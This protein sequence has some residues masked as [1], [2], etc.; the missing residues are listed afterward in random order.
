MTGSAPRRTPPGPRARLPYIPALDSLRAVAVVAVLAYHHDPAAV[1]GGWLGVSLFFTLSGFLIGGLLLAEH[2]REGRVDLAGFWNRRIRRLLPASFVAVALAAVVAVADDRVALGDVLP[3]LRAA[4]LHVANWHFLV[5]DAPYAG[6]ESVPSPVQHYWSLAIE[7]QFYLLFPI[8]VALTARRHL[9]AP[10]MVAVV[11]GSLAVQVTA[12]SDDLDRAYF[13]TDARAAELAV[14]VLLAIALPTIQRVAADHRRLVDLWGVVAMGAGLVLFATA[15]LTSDLL[16]AGGLT[17]VTTVWGGLVV[18][19]VVGQRFPALLDR[20]PLPPI[21]RISY[22]IYLFH[23][24][25]YLLLTSERTGLEGPAL[26]AVRVA[27]TLLLAA[28]SSTVVEL[29]VRRLAVPLRPVLAAAGSGMAVVALGATLLPADDPVD[30]RVDVAARFDAAPEA[31]APRAATAPAPTPATADGAAD[32]AVPAPA[33]PVAVAAEAP[34][35][36]PRVLVVGDSTAGVLGEALQ[37]VG[38]G[39]GRAEVSVLHEPGCATRRYDEALVRSGWVYRTKCGDVFT[40]AVDV[41]AEVRPDAIVV[42]IGS[43]Q[44]LDARYDGDREFRSFLDPGVHVGYR[45]HLAGAVRRLTATGVPIL[46][47][48]VPTPEWDLDAFG[49]MLGGPMPGTG[50]ATSNDPERAA[51][52]NRIDGEV[53]A[54]FP[55]VHRWSLTAA[56]AG[57]DGVIEP[58][59]RTDGLHL[60][61][62]EARRLAREVLFDLL[63]DGYRAVVGRGGAG[64]GAGGPT[65]WSP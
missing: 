15:E 36:P 9:L 27:A 45:D 21:G 31:R 55:A 60:D 20:G 47:A 2:D 49:E 37:E 24:P 59:Q 35:R 23:W 50:E 17:A 32:P 33:V 39:T 16:G 54:G 7:E 57:P 25:V 6:L 43:S 41:S 18:T 13:G 62:A 22:G 40:D 42:L 44:L 3:D 46:W 63:R 10:A 51:L 30:Q 53:L 48:D 12:A 34:Q 28:V 56:I 5:Q 19:A 26:L 64:L 38:A 65:A 1:P 4:V 52:L 61:E 14:G 8:I 11:A 29:P 58:H